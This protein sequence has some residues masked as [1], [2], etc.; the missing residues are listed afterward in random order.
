MR[1]KN[2][3]NSTTFIENHFLEHNNS[4]RQQSY[5]FI[6][7]SERTIIARNRREEHVRRRRRY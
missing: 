1:R 4:C 5:Q 7:R 3:I 6:V 2:R